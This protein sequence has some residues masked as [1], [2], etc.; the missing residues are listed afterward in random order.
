MRNE[1]PQIIPSANAQVPQL[2]LYQ[3]NLM[4]EETHIRKRKQENQWQNRYFYRHQTNY[5]VNRKSKSGL[6]ATTSD[7]SKST[8]NAAFNRLP[9]GYECRTAGRY[10]SA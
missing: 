8:E 1:F 2:Q 3:V 4:E 6:P 7:C 5:F 9:D 10:A